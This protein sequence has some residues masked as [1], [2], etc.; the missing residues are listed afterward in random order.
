MSIQKLPLPGG[1]SLKRLIQLLPAQRG[2][3]RDYPF[4]FDRRDLVFDPSRTDFNARNAFIAAEMCRLSY[5]D[6]DIITAE[7][8]GRRY[9]VS[10][11]HDHE[12]DGDMFIARRGDVVFV[13][14]R[15][16]EFFGIRDWGID[17]K[18]ILKN[19]SGSRVHRGFY[20]QLKA[21]DLNRSV[22]ERL[23]REKADG[24]RHFVFCGHSLGAALA[25]LGAYYY[26]TG[27]VLNSADIR[28]LT[29]GGPRVGDRIFARQCD[30]LFSS[31]YR[32]V[33]NRDIVPRLPPFRRYFH[34]G[35]L[36]TLSGSEEVRLQDAF[37]EERGPAALV[38]F[39]ADAVPG[40][41]GLFRS[42]WDHLPLHYSVILWNYAANAGGAAVTER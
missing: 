26:L 19:M 17:A 2:A 33:H 14:Y 12:H 23:A 40:L 39:L 38:R 30:S 5:E 25:Q 35:K 21:L 9:S 29:F 11:L 37:T 7:L 27:G 4:F 20:K 18:A 42:F 32:V 41:R 36:A 16:T 22:G 24:A 8:A 1:I 34:A 3:R 15:G 31:F 10:V 6:A 28:L 13:V